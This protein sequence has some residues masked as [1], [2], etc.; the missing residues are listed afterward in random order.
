MLKPGKTLTTCT[1]DV[2]DVVEGK[3]QHV[4]IGLVT[5]MHVAGL[6]D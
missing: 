6:D 1:T 2:Y 3:E 4:L 5:K